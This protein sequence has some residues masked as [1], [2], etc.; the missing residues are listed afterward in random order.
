[1][2]KSTAFV[3]RRDSHV[4]RDRALKSGQGVSRR[5]ITDPKLPGQ[6][7]VLGRSDLAKVLPSFGVGPNVFVDIKSVVSDVEFDVTQARAMARSTVVFEQAEKG[8]PIIDLRQDIHELVIDGKTVDPKRYITVQ[9]PDKQSQMGVVGVVL[10][11]GQHTVEMSYSL[12]DRENLNFERG[13]VEFFQRSTDLSPRGYSE[14]YFPSNFEYDQYP[15]VMTLHLKGAQHPHR[16]MS[17]G[18][19]ED[20]GDGRFKVTYPEHFNT[21]CPFLH[22][23]DP[24]KYTILDEIYPGKERPIPMRIYSRSA[25]A[26]KEAL[27]KSKAV[28]KENEAAIGPYAHPCW[29]VCLDPTYPGGMEYAGATITN[30]S[31]LAHELTHSWYARGVMPR[32]GNSGWLDEAFAKWRDRGYPRRRPGGFGHPQLAR[33]SPWRRHTPREASKAG[34]DF[35]SELDYVFRDKGGLRPVMAEMYLQ[36][37]HQTITTEMFE[38]FVAARADDPAEIASLFRS[39]VYNETQDSA[40]KIPGSRQVA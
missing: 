14:R 21:A 28:M 5:G 40:E 15:H 2:I 11:A 13:G 19:V 36:F 30:A 20:L 23:I 25:Q 26:A 29:T 24:A 18:E 6:T 32:G 16:V 38:A 17:N 34:S 31:A 22:I 9:D 39:R 7:L 4:A 8:Q 3:P 10:P 27:A 1:M 37:K 35:L 33:F 12:R